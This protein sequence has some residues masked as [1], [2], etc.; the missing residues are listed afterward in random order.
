MANL[1]TFNG[2]TEKPVVGVAYVMTFRTWPIPLATITLVSGTFPPG[3]I[4]TADE[5]HGTP[6]T[7]GIYSFTVQTAAV[8]QALELEVLPAPQSSLVLIAADGNANV[9]VVGQP[10]LAWLQVGGGG[11]ISTSYTFSAIAGSLPPGLRLYQFPDAPGAVAVLGT[12]AATGTFQFTLQC[13]GNLGD[14][15]HQIVTMAVNDLQLSSDTGGP[16]SM[17]LPPVLEGTA[18]SFQLSQD[19]A[20]S[21]PPSAG[22]PPWSFYPPFASGGTGPP[23]WLTMT[24]AGLLTGTP[25]GG[26]GVDG[27]PAFNWNIAYEIS[28]FGRS[29][30]VE[31]TVLALPIP[32][33][34]GEFHGTYTGIFS[35]G[36]IGGGTV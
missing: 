33:A 34:T 14:T 20:S 15:G 10:C 19:F 22:T 24:T 17:I 23:S 29:N 13:V 4:L 36:Q 16:T 8:T 21:C 32:P 3:L 6:T 30:F 18:F 2:N 1:I 12:P 11:S 9:T 31:L 28:G 25:P 27:G 35:A 7:P 26:S 5:L